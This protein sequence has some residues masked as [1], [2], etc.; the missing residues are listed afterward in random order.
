[1]AT[2]AETLAAS[3]PQPAAPTAPTKETA[4]NRAP[5]AAPSPNATPPRPAR[6]PG[7]VAPPVHPL[8]RG[9][10]TLTYSDAMSLA[11]PVG[12]T[13]WIVRDLQIAPGRPILWT[14]PAGSGK[15]WL[16]MAL[17]LTVA[18]AE[19]TWISFGVQRHGIALHINLEMPEAEIRRRYQRLARGMRLDLG[20]LRLR[21]TNRIDVPGKFDLFSDDA[22]EVLAL[23]VKGVT[24]CVIDSLRAFIGGVDENK[25]EVRLAL[26]VLLSV[27]ERTGCTFVVV[28]HEGK[29]PKEVQA[30]STQHRARGSSAIVD[31]CDCTFSVSTA[32]FPC[33]MRIEQGKASMG[34]KSEPFFVK[35]VDEGAVDEDGRSSAIRIEYVFPEEAEQIAAAEPAPVARARE[36]ILEALRVHGSLNVRN[37]ATG[38]TAEGTPYVRGNKD[39]KHRAVEGLLADGMIVEERKAHARVFR[40]P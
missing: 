34:K 17:A 5:A 26:D 10:R 25:S 20:Q 24:L 9:A 22:V 39:A 23:A 8:E 16:A 27:S 28:H 11:Q 13:P 12:P 37:I 33:G 7:N 4:P 38:R 32:E 36:A 35:L 3:V 6:L 31:A 19:P 30:G 2:P 18:S 15:T 40:L 14:A 29:P 1:M 21:A